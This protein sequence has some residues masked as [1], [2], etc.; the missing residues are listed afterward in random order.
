MKRKQHQ[1]GFPFPLKLY[2]SGERLGDLG[3]QKSS[4]QKGLSCR[5]HVQCCHV[6]TWG[7]VIN[8]TLFLSACIQQ[9]RMLKENIFNSWTQNCWKRGN[10]GDQFSFLDQGIE[11]SETIQRGFFYRAIAPHFLDTKWIVTNFSRTQTSDQ[12]QFG[13]SFA[14]PGLCHGIGKARLFVF[15]LSLK[16]TLQHKKRDS[17]VHDSRVKYI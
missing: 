12:K 10:S 4:G 14:T 5:T 7:C 3:V 13:N 17:K 1:A 16:K 11:C 9:S 8:R 15:F 6:T 2:K